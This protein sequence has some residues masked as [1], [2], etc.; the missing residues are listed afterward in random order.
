M[1]ACVDVQYDDTSGTAKAAVASFLN[2]SSPRAS[3]EHVVS[4]SVTEPYVAGQFYKRELPCLLSVLGLLS[5]VPDVVLVDGYVWLAGGAEGLGAHL[6]RTFAG[7]AVV[8]VAKRAFE[9]TPS[10]RV[11]RGRARTPLFVTSVGI[12]LAQA[13]AGVTDMHGQY[14]IPTLLKR[15]DHLARGHELPVL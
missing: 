11:F 14:R 6:Y 3:E 5:T 15:V 7:P 10:S 1:F 8:G 2:W 12:S 13:S 9:G 4:L